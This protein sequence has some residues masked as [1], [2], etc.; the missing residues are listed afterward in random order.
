MC[1]HLPTQFS[2]AADLLDCK[3]SKID[4]LPGKVCTYMYRTNVGGAGVYSVMVDYAFVFEN[5][6]INFTCMIG[7][8][9][10][11]QVPFFAKYLAEYGPVFLQMA[12]SIVVENKWK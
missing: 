3:P 7:S 11:H 1:H 10:I 2:E 8:P 6:L 9:D 12:N 4:G 5:K